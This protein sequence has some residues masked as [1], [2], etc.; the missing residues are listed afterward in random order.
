MMRRNALTA[1]VDR[2]RGVRDL[3]GARGRRH[4][5]G[6]SGQWRHRQGH[7]RRQP[8][9]RDSKSGFGGDRA[10]QPKGVAVDGRFVYW[11]SSGH[12]TIGRANIDGSNANPN[13]ITAHVNHPEAVVVR[14]GYI[15]WSNTGSGTI[16]RD[17]VDGNPANIVDLINN[18]TNPSGLAV[19]DSHVYWTNGAGAPDL[20]V[21]QAT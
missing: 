1:L 19:D 20:D 4:L 12:S 9:E 6:E 10:F 11:T 8:S 13:F 5:L 16:S 18:Q 2:A 14:S 21:G 3:A 17:T 15:Y 7:D